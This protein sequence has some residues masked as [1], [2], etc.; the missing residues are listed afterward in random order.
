[1]W[2]LGLLIMAVASDGDLAQMKL[3][4]GLHRKGL[5]VTLCLILSAGNS[6]VFTNFRCEQFGFS[7]AGLLAP[8]VGV[9][10]LFFPKLGGETSHETSCKGAIRTG[11]VYGAAGRSG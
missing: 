7:F 10:L 3:C 5:P 9:C 1:M 4:K 6:F 11:A 8:R 2:P